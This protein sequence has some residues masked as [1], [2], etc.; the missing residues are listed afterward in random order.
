M[1]MRRGLAERLFNQLP[2]SRIATTTIVVIVGGT[3]RAADSS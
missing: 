1:R 2:Q 3:K